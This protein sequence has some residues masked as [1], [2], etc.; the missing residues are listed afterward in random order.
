MRYRWV[1]M[2][3]NSDSINSAATNSACTSK[4]D[5]NWVGFQKVQHFKHLKSTT[6][7]KVQDFKHLTSTF[8]S[9]LSC[10]DL[11]WVGLSYCLYSV[12]KCT[13][14][15][16]TVYLQCTYCVPTRSSSTS[17]P[18][19]AFISHQTSA[20]SHQPSV[21][22]SHQ[23]TYSVPIMYLQVSHLLAIFPMFY[24]RCTHGV[25]TVYLRRT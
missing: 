9:D 20:I 4:L 23:C 15:V 1:G 12:P 24:L 18:Q 17:S 10:T 21:I 6:F 2:A 22:I 14:S 13:Y 7:Q 5:Q 8:V 11:I 25:P 16:P 3:T 19:P